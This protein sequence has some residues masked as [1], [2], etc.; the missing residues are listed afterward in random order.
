MP[1]LLLLQLLKLLLLPLLKSLLLLLPRRLTRPR[2]QRLQRRL[3]KPSLVKL[4]LLLSN[5]GFLEVQKSSASA[6]LFS[7]QLSDIRQSTCNLIHNPAGPKC[8]LN[9]Q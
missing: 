9:R 3:K 6:L 8:I 1:S 7:F 5:F 4:L 2:R